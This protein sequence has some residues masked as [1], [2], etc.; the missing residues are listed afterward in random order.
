MTSII[1]KNYMMNIIN[2][3]TSGLLAGKV[4]LV[5]EGTSGIDEA[6]A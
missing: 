1:I 2:T 3:E 6:A 4:A 5:V